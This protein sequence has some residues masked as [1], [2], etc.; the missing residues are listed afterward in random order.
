[1]GCI[2]DQGGDVRE[3]V[4]EIIRLIIKN[5]LFISD[6]ENREFSV[7][8]YRYDFRISNISSSKENIKELTTQNET[9]KEKV[10]D[11]NNR[12]KGMSCF[13]Y[14]TPREGFMFMGFDESDYESLLRNN[15]A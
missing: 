5:D 9:Y 10:I 11:F 8:R 15:P 13:R 3:N 7:G 2:Q 4:H 1:M 12:K 14:L 6:N